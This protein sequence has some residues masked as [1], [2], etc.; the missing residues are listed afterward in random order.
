MDSGSIKEILAYRTGTNVGKYAHILPWQ[1][2]PSLGKFS[3]PGTSGT[4]N[5]QPTELGSGFRKKKLVRII[6]L[7]I[8]MLAKCCTTNE[9]YCNSN[10]NRVSTSQCH[11]SVVESMERPEVT[12]MH[13]E[14]HVW[15]Q[16]PLSSLLVVKR[17]SGRG[18]LEM[19]APE[20]TTNTCP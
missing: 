2:D 17:S 14:R 19:T 10:S 15:S 5:C 6:L 8:P 1:K 7:F 20:K 12:T 18:E 4:W 13:V 11:S 9:K 16:H 3:L